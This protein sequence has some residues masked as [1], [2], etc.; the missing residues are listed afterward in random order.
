MKENGS[1]VLKR[2]LLDTG[3]NQNLITQQTAIEIGN[4]IYQNNVQLSVV[5]GRR[6][7]CHQEMNIQIASNNVINNEIFT[8]EITCAILEN[9][10]QVAPYR[11]FDERNFPDM[12]LKLERKPLADSCFHY[13]GGIDIIL[14]SDITFKCL[15][16][17]KI[18]MD[19]GVVMRK[20]KLGYIATGVC[21]DQY[22]HE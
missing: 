19:C 3:A 20:S 5:G 11:N 10:S 17:E 14:N 21:V 16:D 7:E 4:T 6:F 18:L 12:K 13:P 1:Y 8:E 2:V 15:L 22:F 9:L